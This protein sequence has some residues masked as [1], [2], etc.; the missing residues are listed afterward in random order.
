MS[1]SGGKM[2][3]R[4]LKNW[5]KCFPKSIKEGVDKNACYD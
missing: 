4:W 2:M 1:R 3:H 5:A